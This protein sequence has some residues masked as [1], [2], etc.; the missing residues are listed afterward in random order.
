VTRAGV[1]VLAVRMQAR[2]VTALFES[3]DLIAVD[4]QAREAVSESARIWRKG[5]LRMTAEPF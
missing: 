1:E 4:S 2:S 5:L 3:L